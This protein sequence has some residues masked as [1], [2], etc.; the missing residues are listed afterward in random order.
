MK[1][2]GQSETR[3]SVEIEVH[4][5]R[6]EMGRRLMSKCGLLSGGPAPEGC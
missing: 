6:R 2:L 1:P 5:R 3:S 4:N